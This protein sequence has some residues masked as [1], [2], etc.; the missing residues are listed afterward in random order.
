MG[1]C[2]PWWMQP[3]F[4]RQ[5]SQTTL[6]TVKTDAVARAAQQQLDQQKLP[7][8]LLSYMMERA[9]QQAV[10][11]AVLEREAD[12]L[13]LEVSAADL[14]RELKTGALS[15]YLFPDGK[16]IGDDGYINFVESNFRMSVTDF[17]D[18][19]RSDLELQRL[20]ALVITV[21]VTVVRCGLC[22]RSL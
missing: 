7:A 9:G 22:A 3:G 14:Q 16:F 20:Q 6:K 15:T 12:K 4:F 11:R 13:G 21:A 18:A 17:E 10:G 19:V 8:F 1:R 2:M 5:A